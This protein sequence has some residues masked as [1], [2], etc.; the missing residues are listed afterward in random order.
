MAN[1]SPII[2]WVVLLLGGA[3]SAFG[4]VTVP[5]HTSKALVRGQRGEQRSAEVGFDPTTNIV[6]VKLSVDDVDGVFIPNL[7]RNNFAVYEDGVRQKDVTVEV[8]H[9]PVTLAVLMEMGGR[10][11]Q[12]NRML[13]SDVGYVARPVLDVLGG[14]DRLALFSY[15][16]QVHTIIDFDAPH[17]KWVAAL[18]NL[19]VPKFSEAN[20][21]DAVG[22][23]LDRLASTP[24]RKALLVISTGIDTFSHL[25]FDEVARKA[26]AANT[27]IYVISLGGRA[28]QS[29]L[30]DHGPLARV[31]WS[32]CEQQLETLA[33]LSGGRAYVGA[34]T[35]EAPAL[36]DDIMENL[37]VRYVI[38]YAATPS[39]STSASRT[40]QVTLVDPK[41]D[42]P[43][44]IADA[45]GRPVTVQT[46]ARASYTPSS[47]TR[48]AVETPSPR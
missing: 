7:R 37:R 24:G 43:L 44:R 48:A 28:R 38:T 22:D 1:R 23:V 12:L 11:Q 40:V 32:A 25:T 10:S 17:E 30:V 2:G 33:H 36:F 46:I 47:A 21:Y 6:T 15:D 4:Q 39:V 29:S 45:S 14:E 42:Q 19:S 26:E 3:A 8:E 20:F 18:T 41:S 9:A 31:D 27:P 5:N 13:A 34:N 35:V 16:D